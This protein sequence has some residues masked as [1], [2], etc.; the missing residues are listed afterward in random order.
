MHIAEKLIEGRRY[1]YLQRSYRA[2]DAKTGQSKVKTSS[3]YLGKAETVLERLKQTKRPLEVSVKEFGFI[4]ALVQVSRDIGLIELL[5]EHFPGERYGVPQW[6]YFFTSIINRLQQATS[7]EQMGTWAQG[8]ILPELFEFEAGA[9]NSRSFWYA[10]EDVVSESELKAVR[11][12]KELLSTALTSGAKID[13]SDRETATEILSGLVSDDTLKAAGELLSTG[14]TEDNIGAARETK[15]AL[16]DDPM[17]GIDEKV[18]HQIVE[19]LFA[20]IKSRFEIPKAAMLYDTTNF[21]TYIDEPS[22]S[23][24]ARVGH[25]KDSH[26]HLRQVGLALAADKL[27]GIPFFYRVY[28]G[29]SHDSKTFGAVAHAMIEQIKTTFPDVEDLVLIMDK[30]NNSKQNFDLLKGK[31]KW[32]GSLVPSRYPELVAKPPAEYSEHY[33]DILYS[34]VKMKV[35]DADCLVVSTYRPSLARKQLHTI[36]AGLEKLTHEI[37]S[38]FDSYKSPQTT[39]PAGITTLLK[40]NRHGKY[41]EVAVHEGRLLYMLKKAKSDSGRR[42]EQRDRDLVK[43]TNAIQQKFEA[44]KTPPT[45]VP[46]AIN[47]MLKK[48]RYAES[49]ELTVCDSGGLVYKL[50]QA[51]SEESPTISELQKTKQTL[52]KNLLFTDNVSATA[53]WLIDNYQGKYKIEDCFALMKSADL[54]R[55]RPIRHFTDTK[56]CAFA[57]CCVMALMLIKVLQ[58]ICMQSGLA[59]SPYLLK[60]ELSD[61]KIATL[62]YGPKDVSVEVTKRSSVQEKMW[63]LFRLGEIADLLNLLPGERPTKTSRM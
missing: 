48:S 30:G 53:T 50:S 38:K 32:V 24:L 44:Y 49:L 34:A 43:L 16:N 7:K 58:L 22:R 6:L 28:R 5:Q 4:A 52:G 27:Y 36:H 12:A 40:E 35:M 10:M 56:I 21:F 3:T 37:Q 1:Y 45:S 20:K 47:T 31:I 63:E 29:N 8:T 41:L 14:I 11:A 17:I 23:E 13:E 51:D 26:H 2:K 39:V 46:N 57:F 9:L 61:I 62:L 33:Q 25:N 55:F 19:K 42:Q 15:N 59:M 18:F 60:E 54:I